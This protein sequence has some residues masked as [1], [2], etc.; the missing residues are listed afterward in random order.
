MK[1]FGIGLLGGI[2]PLAIFMMSSSNPTSPQSDTVFGESGNGYAHNASFNGLAEG[3]PVDNFVAASENSL[4][5]VVHVTTKVVT[6]SFERDI[7]SEFFYGP[8]AGG[9]EF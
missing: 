5:S 6:T 8:G 2:L 7:F 9:R 3:L 4:N 1:I